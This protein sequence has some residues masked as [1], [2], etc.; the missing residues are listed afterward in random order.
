MK[1]QYTPNICDVKR[2]MGDLREIAREASSVEVFKM[3]S[4]LYGDYLLHLSMMQE[5]VDMI[6]S[7]ETD[8]AINHLT[9]LQSATTAS[10][11]YYAVDLAVRIS[12]AADDVNKVIDKIMEL[13]DK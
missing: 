11:H 5:A 6:R 3:L 13:C 8:D 12:L 7:G 4:D 10:N 9:I 2:I 1:T